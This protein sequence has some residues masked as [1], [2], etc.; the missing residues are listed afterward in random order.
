MLSWSP[1]GK[2]IVVARAKSLVQYKPDLKEAKS[3]AFDAAALGMDPS[4][5]PSACSL[6]WLSNFQFAAAFVDSSDRSSRPMVFIV[7]TPKGAAPTFTNFDDICYGSAQERR[8][9]S[10]VAARAIYSQSLY[11][12]EFK[13]TINQN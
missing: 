6:L 3:I 8:Q 1:K 5:V 4:A 10:V 9:R 12:C 2:Q 7:D 13:L 11:S